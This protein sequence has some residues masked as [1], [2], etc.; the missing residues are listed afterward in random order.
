MM[1]ARLSKMVRRIEKKDIKEDLRK[2]VEIDRAQHRLER[3][4][5]TALEPVNQGK[6]EGILIW[7][8]K[9]NPYWLRMKLYGLIN[10]VCVNQKV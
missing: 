6:L 1:N 7:I 4:V 9:Y 5:L 10:P 8:A 3:I 2:P